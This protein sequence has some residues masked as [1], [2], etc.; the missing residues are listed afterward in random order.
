MSRKHNEGRRASTRERGF[1]LIEVLIALAIA[2]L[3][4][5]ALMAAA[6]T[7][8]GNAKRAGQYIE[9]TRRAQSHLALIGATTPLQPGDWSGDDGAG[10][11]WR[12]RIAP[13]AV[14]AAAPG[15]EAASSIYTLEVTIGWQSGG[16]A[17]SVT[18]QSQRLASAPQ[19][20]G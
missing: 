12:V 7:G 9:A 3:G 18:L 5:A 4:L 11:S 17:N 20:N 10:F 1:T 6:S 8:L 13:P 16:T 15:G 2:G 19:N 14:H